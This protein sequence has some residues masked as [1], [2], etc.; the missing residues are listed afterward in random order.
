MS[1]RTLVLL[2]L[3]FSLFYFSELGTMPLLEPDEGRYAEIPREML[4]SGDFVTPHL[5]G[6]AY[7]EK[8]PFFYW[9]NAL[10]L[11]LL[12]ENEFAARGFTAAASVAGI[13]LTYWMGSAL[14]GWR[15]GLFSAIVL[16][17]SLYYYVIGRLNTLDMTLAISLLL[18]IFPAYLYLS[19]KRESRGYLHLSYAAAGIAFLTKGLVGMVFPAAILVSWLA[20]S[21]KH[22]EIPRG[23]SLPGILL[24]LGVVL[25]WIFLV[26]RK[27]PDFLW[28]FFVHEQFL[29]YTTKIHHRAA[30]FWYF[31]PIVF[32]GFVPWIAFLRRIFL[33]ARDA[34]KDFF[35]R[36]DLIFLLSWVLF[37]FLFFSFS[38]SKLATYAAPIFPP[39]AVLFG[40]G[41]DLWAEREDGAVRCR[42]PLALAALMAAAIFWLPSFSRHA[43]DP[44]VWLKLTAL[45]IFLVLLWGTVPLFLRRLSAER[46][47]LLSFLLLALFLTSLNRPAARYIGAYKSAKE[48]AAVLNS[49][50][51]PG[52]VVA[53]YDTYRQGIPFYTKRRSVLVEEVGEMEFGAD[54]AKD[55]E[56]YF[57]NDAAFQR[58]WTSG[59]R[60][61]CVFKRDAMPLLREKF[62]GHRLLYR[63]DAGILVV[64]RP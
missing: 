46:V 4:A 52:D 28:F 12:G 38:G 49:S 29:R 6:V 21:R 13:L 8:P 19:G 17:T 41:L 27:N 20:L 64:N 25:P 14:A 61:F 53:Q 44:S 60:V 42:S 45:P 5:N 63:S 31:L 10:S 39:L 35:P 51:R 59:A 3:A 55:R 33:A 26:Q 56:E 18:A 1:R 54:R 43:V 15:T 48:M 58:L 7:L 37:I 62:P 16:S 34:G 22:R 36:E 47:V 24:F 40:R 50:L 30:P 11:R 23:I 57:L 2:F 32:G 9:G